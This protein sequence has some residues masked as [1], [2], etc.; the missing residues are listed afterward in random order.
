ML[1]VTNLNQYYGSSHTLRDVSFDVPSRRCW[2]ATAWA[3]PR[4][5]SA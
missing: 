5:S 4:C 1:T 3:R 2:G